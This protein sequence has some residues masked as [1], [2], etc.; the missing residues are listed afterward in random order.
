MDIKIDVWS[1]TCNVGFSATR[2][3]EAQAVAATRVLEEGLGPSLELLLEMHTFLGGAQQV[4]GSF[5]QAGPV[6]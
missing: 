2:R 4:F 5:H 3:D 6:F 1:A